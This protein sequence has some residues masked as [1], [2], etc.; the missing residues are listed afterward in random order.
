MD[1]QR[2]QQLAGILTESSS[3]GGQ[4]VAMHKIA[5][6]SGEMMWHDEMGGGHGQAGMNL[7]DA[8]YILSIIFEEDEEIIEDKLLSLQ[9]KY[10]DEA[11]SNH[12]KGI[13]SYR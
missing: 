1:K 6:K 3:S 4:D 7:G 8:A 11:H 2:L 13:E 9:T 5:K 10:H 12:L